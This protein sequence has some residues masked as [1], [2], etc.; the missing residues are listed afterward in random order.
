VDA[1][2]AVSMKTIQSDREHQKRLSAGEKLNHDEFFILI[3]SPHM[4][5]NELLYTYTHIRPDLCEIITRH[6]TESWENKFVL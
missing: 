6:F 2:S 3:F 1:N 5:A 4:D